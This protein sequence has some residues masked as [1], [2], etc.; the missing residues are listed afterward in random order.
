MLADIRL[1]KTK[2][3]PSVTMLVSQG[4]VE[5]EGESYPENSAEFFQPIYDWLERFTDQVKTHLTVNMRLSYF[6]TSSSKCI[7][8]VLDIL[9]S[10]HNRSGG[11]VT[12]TWFYHE[13]DEDMLESGR[14]FIEDLDMNFKLVSYK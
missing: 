11:A 6:N 3:T 5:L 2:V 14:E 10:Y 4:L 8:D 7:L 12:V 1:E 9:Q 13:E